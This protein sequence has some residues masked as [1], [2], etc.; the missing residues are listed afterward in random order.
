MKDAQEIYHHAVDRIGEVYSSER[1]LNYGGNAMGVELTLRIYHD[2]WAYIMERG[3]DL[4]YELIRVIE[5]EQC[6]A[7]SFST[8]Y[9]WEHPNASEGDTAQYVISQWKKVSLALGITDGD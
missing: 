8:R 3:D 4:R 6:S 1:P 9:R 7:A 2:L 5:Q